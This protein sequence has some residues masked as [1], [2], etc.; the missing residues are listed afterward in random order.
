MTIS[1]SQFNQEI[2]D[3]ARATRTPLVGAFELTRSCN[4]ACRMCYVRKYP[5]AG[6]PLSEQ[7]SAGQWLEI[8]R[9]AAKAGMLYLLLTGGEIFLRPDFFEI[10]EGLYKLG[11][12]ISLNTN[13]TLITPTIAERLA[14]HPP[15]TVAVTIYGA[16]PA[17]YADV[18]GDATGFER[19]LRG[20]RLLDENKLNVR[21]R[22]TVIRQNLADFE[23]IYQL[24]QE[25]GH[26][27]RLVDYVF[28]ED[29]EGEDPYAVRLSPV[30]QRECASRL[31]GWIVARQNEELKAGTEEQASTEEED[32]DPTDIEQQ[33]EEPW[34]EAKHAFLCP[35]GNYSFSVNAAGKLLACLLMDEPGLGMGADVSLGEAWKQL[36]DLCEAVPVCRECAECE[37]RAHCS[38][39]P[40]KLKTETGAFAKK[41]PYLCQMAEVNFAASKGER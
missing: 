26:G 30:E 5:A 18:S 31:Y 38:V 15:R 17:T 4:L 8:G 14:Q 36:K 16:S 35:A 40:A 23:K 37:I 22:T 19:V 6:K 41:A 34:K 10:Y 28:A 12:Q 3:K 27:L 33:R 7:L 39:C 9:Q 13:A 1:H 29:E 11:L 25:L 21:L 2:F 20:I 24:S 32:N